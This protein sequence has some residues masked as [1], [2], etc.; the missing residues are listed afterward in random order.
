MS[1]LYG[2]NASSL[3][4]SDLLVADTTVTLAPGE[5]DQFPLPDAGDADSFAMLTLE[6][7]GGNIEIVKMTERSGDILTIERAQEDTAPA[8]FAI[9]S[10]IEARLTAGSLANFKQVSDQYELRGDLIDSDG[11]RLWHQ[12]DPSTYQFFTLR[13][14]TLDIFGVPIM[15]IE[16]P[17]GIS[18]LSI[19]LT[20][21]G[22]DGTLKNAGLVP[23]LAGTAP[24][25]AT[26][27]VAWSVPGVQQ[28]VAINNGLLK[29]IMYGTWEYDVPTQTY[30]L[31]HQA[32]KTNPVSYKW[33]CRDEFEVSRPVTVN[34]D[35]SVTGWDV[36]R[37]HHAREFDYTDATV[38]NISYDLSSTNPGDTDIVRFLRS[39]QSTSVRRLAYQFQC[40]AAIAGTD[41]VE[42][43]TKTVVFNTIGQIEMP[44]EGTAA[45]HAVTKGYVDAAVASGSSGQGLID[46][47][48]SIYGRTVL[49]NNAA[50]VNDGSSQTLTGGAFSDF[51]EIEVTFNDSGNDKFYSMCIDTDTLTEKGYSTG[52]AVIPNAGT[53]QDNRLAYF[54]PTSD[55]TFTATHQNLSAGKCVKII[56]KYPK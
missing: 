34:S 29:P 46:L 24:A 16:A 30:Q 47:T 12:Q 51:A 53:G 21:T 54:N 48:A 4:I 39:N 40:R 2:N 27:E 1:Q 49:W 7:V 36:W 41:P 17:P 33:V 18:G 5:G 35:G 25:P 11:L 50:G 44:S 13:Y 23:N 22:P 56:G 37:L 20:L 28:W 32:D 8:G 26:G 43:E 14:Y 52:W 10:R 19:Y 6:D 3:I 55:T 38:F 31:A 15:Q 45:T 42:Y 9:G